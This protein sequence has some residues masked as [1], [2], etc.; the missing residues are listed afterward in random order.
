MV[1]ENPYWST[2][3]KVNMLQRWILVH[4]ILY[5]EKDESLVQDITYD[6]NQKQLMDM[7]KKLTSEEKEKTRYWYVFKDF[8]GSTGFDLV[9]KLKRK[10]K[11]FLLNEAESILAMSRRW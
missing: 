2:I 3:L 11:N 4:S 10:D 6:M 8:K 1:F 7:M 5:Y 9:S